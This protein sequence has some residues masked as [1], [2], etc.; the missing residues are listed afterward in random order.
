L[1]NHPSNKSSHHQQPHRP[2]RTPPSQRIKVKT[3]PTKPQTRPSSGVVACQR[4][5][6]PIRACTTNCKHYGI[7]Q[8]KIRKMVVEAE[9]EAKN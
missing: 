4:G 8:E 2:D 6:A 3:V 9:N 1:A 5:K 7:G